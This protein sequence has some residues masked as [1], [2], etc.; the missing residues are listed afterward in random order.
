MSGGLLGLY[1]LG[2]LTR[3]GDGRSAALAIAA[4]LALSV[5]R[6]LAATSWFPAGLR[7]PALDAVHGYYTA[8]LAHTVM[9][10]VGW[11]AGLALPRRRRIEDAA[12]A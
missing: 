9:F 2:F 6:A 5:Y 8:L 12:A 3:R 1:L 11:L 7:L 10:G 4:T